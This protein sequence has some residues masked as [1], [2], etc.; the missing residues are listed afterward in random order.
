MRCMEGKS[1]T[2][3]DCA[4]ENPLGHTGENTLEFY[5]LWGLIVKNIPL[6][7]VKRNQYGKKAIESRIKQKRQDNQRM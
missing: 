1:G 2:W 4:G 3:P 5:L 7:V 6:K